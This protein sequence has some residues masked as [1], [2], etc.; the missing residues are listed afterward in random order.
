MRASLQVECGQ[1]AL[2]FR[3]LRL[4][5]DYAVKIQ[6]E[7]DHPTTS[8]MKDCWKNTNAMYQL[9]REPFYTKVKEVLDVIKFADV[10]EVPLETAPWMQQPPSSKSAHAQLK[11]IFQQIAEL[12]TSHWQKAWENEETARSTSPPTRRQIQ[13]QV[14]HP[15][16]TEGQNDHPP[17][18][19]A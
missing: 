15:T 17:T 16:T 1:P 12:M 7:R 14:P 13:D 11:P 8:I 18:P 2:S 19:R 4:Q 6:S 5:S 9:N 10:S 3:R